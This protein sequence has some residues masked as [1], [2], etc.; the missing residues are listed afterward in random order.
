MGCYARPKA[1]L[2]PPLEDFE[3]FATQWTQAS[4][5]AQGIRETPEVEREAWD[6]DRLRALCAKH[7]WEFEWMTEDGERRRRTREHKGLL[8]L[9]AGVPAPRPLPCIAPDTAEPDGSK[10]IPSTRV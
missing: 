6:E 7:G 9:P 4:S 1:N 10:E 5:L 2:R 8:Q 3:D